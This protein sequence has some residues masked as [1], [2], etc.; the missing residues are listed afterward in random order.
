MEPPVPLLASAVMTIDRVLARKMWRTLEPYH[1]MI[2]FVPEAEQEYVSAGLKP[3][4][5]GYFSS[6][7]AAMGPVPGEVVVATFFNFNPDLVHSVIPAAWALAS[8]EQILAARFRAADASLRR[9]LGD[10]IDSVELA[11]AAALART[12]TEG[13]LRPDGRPLYAGHASLP[14]P[15]DPHLVLW[16]AITLLREYRGDGHIAALVTDGVTGLQALVMHAAS[17]DV[18]ADVLRSTRAWSEG[19]WADAVTELGRRGWVTADGGFTDEGRAHRQEVED[20][21]DDLALAP[22]N[23][24][25]PEGCDRLRSLVRPFSKAISERPF[26]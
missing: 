1:G 19:E 9:L 7:S 24:L 15:D 22:W 4:R 18:P 13:E 20:R 6:R 3:G 5:M 26:R 21:T 17:G 12:A 8:P 14:W 25:G 23:A 11:E 10:D 2:Y 16:H